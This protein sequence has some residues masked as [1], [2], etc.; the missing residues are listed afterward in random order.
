MSTLTVPEAV[1][2]SQLNNDIPYHELHGDEPY[3][4]DTDSE[5]YS[6]D[7]VEVVC[8]ACDGV[9]CSEVKLRRN[10]DDVVD[11]HL[12]LAYCEWCHRLLYKAEGYTLMPE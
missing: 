4:R 12:L 1:F 3:R 2:E 5:T 9:V 8:P 10:C 11:E 6:G 7:P